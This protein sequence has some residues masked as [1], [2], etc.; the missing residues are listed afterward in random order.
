MTD[1]DPEQASSLLSSSPQAQLQQSL[2]RRLRIAYLLLGAVV[3]VFLALTAAVQSRLMGCSSS[4][5]TSTFSKSQADAAAQDPNA[6][7]KFDRLVDWLMRNGA[8]VDGVAAKRM[9][10][11]GGRGVYA[12]RDLKQGELVMAIP[13]QLWIGDRNAHAASAVGYIISKDSVAREYAEREG[14]AWALIMMMEYE[15]YNPYSFYKPYTD[16]IPKPASPV[17][18]SQE[19]VRNF[20]SPSIERKIH[21]YRKSVVDGYEGLMKHLIA[22]YPLM[23][24]AENNTLDSFAHTTITAWT[25]TFDVSHSGDKVKESALV[26]M[27]DLLNHKSGTPM[28]HW[29]LKYADEEDSKAEGKSHNHDPTRRTPTAQSFDFHMPEDKPNE[30]QVVISY[31]DRRSAFSWVVWAGFIPD[32]EF[33]DYL[34]VQVDVDK[35][36]GVMPATLPRDR[37]SIQKKL[38][39]WVVKDGVLPPAFLDSC[40]SLLFLKGEAS[41]FNK[42]TTEEGKEWRKQQWIRMLEWLRDEMITEENILLTTL[43]QDEAEFE[44]LKSKFKPGDESQ[45]HH[46]L[47]L[48]VRVRFKSIIRKLVENLRLAA[49][50]ARENPL[51]LVAKWQHPPNPNTILPD[52]LRDRKSW[53]FDGIMDYGF[54]T[55]TLAA[56]TLESD[57]R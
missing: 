54:I 39:A 17:W 7:L 9:F 37:R 24:S 31:S 10:A 16:F 19:D 40:L 20:Q 13:S 25:R 32:D 48:G 41:L 43:E 56:P 36:L 47:N 14:D 3:V 44:A 23:F 5:V 28:S 21:E 6:D 27:A 49:Q 51:V 52:L 12:T 18:W 2:Q 46:H 57:V 34:T 1:N 53:G 45:F 42:D 26:P 22:E 8:T 33:G 50:E 30:E 38:T 35:A 55:L 15:K 29:R 4:P 11:G